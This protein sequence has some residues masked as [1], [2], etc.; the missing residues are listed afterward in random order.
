MAPSVSFVEVRSGPEI[1]ASGTMRSW[2]SHPYRRREWT[3]AQ[4]ST[5]H[6]ALRLISGAMRKV[7]K[8]KV[9][10]R[11]VP[12]RKVLKRKVLKR[13]LLKRKVLNRKILR[14]KVL[15]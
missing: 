10:K 15:N 6:T 4:S 13:Y 9:L 1:L 3:S 5:C 14:R 12:Q 8:R 2:R 7:L 11:K